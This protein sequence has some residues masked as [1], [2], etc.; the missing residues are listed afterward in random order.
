MFTREHLINGTRY[1]EVLESYRDPVSRRPKHRLIAR[2]N[3]KSGLPQDE[4]AAWVDRGNWSR[5]EVMAFLE[6]EINS[7]KR[8][9]P[10]FRNGGEYEAKLK[11]QVLQLRRAQ[12][13]LRTEKR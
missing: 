13:G 4:R 8:A 12:D 6:A 1:I 11:N 5:A 10:Y 9:L 2:V 3:P 7:V